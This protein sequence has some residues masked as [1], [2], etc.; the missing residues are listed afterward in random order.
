MLKYLKNPEEEVK[1]SSVETGNG[2][3]MYLCITS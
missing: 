1:D 3:T 2:T